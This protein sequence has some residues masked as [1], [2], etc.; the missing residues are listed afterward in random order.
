[1]ANALDDVRVI[2]LTHFYNG[3]YST[4]VLSFLGAEVIK[5][6]PTTPR[7]EGP[8]DLSHTGSFSGEFSLC[9]AQLQQ[10]GYY[11]EPKSPT[12]TGAVQGVGNTR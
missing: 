5:V 6:E 4:L 7:R 11:P 1:M 10:E 12:W 2:D 3:P 8:N 9:N